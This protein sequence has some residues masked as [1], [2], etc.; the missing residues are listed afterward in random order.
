MKMVKGVKIPT[1][2]T[3]SNTYKPEDMYTLASDTLAIFC[4]APANQATLLSPSS[5]LAIP[6][7]LSAPDTLSEL[8]RT[9]WCCLCLPE[10]CP[11]L[12]AGQGCYEFTRSQS[13]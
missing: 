11:E 7:S 6:P 3:Y 9:V 12:G 5:A 13:S 1:T 4:H 2:Q 10:L 8:A